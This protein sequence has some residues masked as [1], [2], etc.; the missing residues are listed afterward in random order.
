MSKV[1][2]KLVAGVIMEFKQSQTSIKISE[3]TGVYLPLLIEII[4]FCI[5]QKTPTDVK[6]EIWPVL[7]TLIFAQALTSTLDTVYTRAPQPGALAVLV[8]AVIY[9]V[10]VPVPSSI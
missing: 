6:I 10:F 1:E 2:G 3:I 7:L 8:G 5:G 4:V 9:K